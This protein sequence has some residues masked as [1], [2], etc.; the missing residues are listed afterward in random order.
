MKHLSSI[1]IH[2]ISGHRPR[3][4]RLAPSLHNQFSFY[5]LVRCE[6]RQ[7]FYYLNAISFQGIYTLSFF[8]AL[9]NKHPTTH[10]TGRLVMGGCFFYFFSSRRRK[11]GIPFASF[12]KE[13][14]E[15]C[16]CQS[17][18]SLYLLHF[19]AAYAIFLTVIYAADR[20]FMNTIFL[21]T[22]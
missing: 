13:D 17:Q 5:T 8:N 12:R 3:D 19:H 21:Y 20:G 1:I 18:R 7:G 11:G 15:F 2:P 22:S 9:L 6:T 16:Y 10:P 4:D 14:I